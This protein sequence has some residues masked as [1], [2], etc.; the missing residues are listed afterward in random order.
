MGYQLII[1][2]ALVT[3]SHFFNETLNLT[4]TTLVI[5]IAIGVHEY[6]KQGC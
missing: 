3:I 6:L 1:R 5:G 2:L 4:I